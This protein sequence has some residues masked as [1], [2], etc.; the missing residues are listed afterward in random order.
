[1]RL[2]L[3]SLTS[4]L[5]LAI[6]A[7]PCIA[8]QVVTSIEELRAALAAGDRVTLIPVSGQPLDG[9][10][11]RL[12]GQD[13]QIRPAR[14]GSREVTVRF[15]QIQSLERLRDPVRNGVT[16][17]AAV[18][19]GAGGAMFLYALAIDRNEIDE[20][21]PFYLGA[22]AACTG[23]GALIG[24]AI[25]AAKSKPYLRFH[26]SPASRA[27]IE[28]HTLPVRGRGLALAVSFSPRRRRGLRAAVM[29]QP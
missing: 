22:T 8:Q 10:V 24:W 5:I 21:A 3:A 2:G 29:V 13:L 27:T 18:G 6:G 4:A 1:M 7:S 9:R 15:D 16:I 23:V 20:W 28:I 25:D 14:G 26:V 19:A 17:G 11:I 12:G